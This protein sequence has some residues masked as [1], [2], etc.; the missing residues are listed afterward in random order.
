MTIYDVPVD[1]TVFF[2]VSGDMMRRMKFEEEQRTKNDL[3]SPAKNSPEAADP[4]HIHEEQTVKNDTPIM[5]ED[6]DV[7]RHPLWC[8]E[9]KCLPPNRNGDA[10]LH[11]QNIGSVSFKYAYDAIV[12]MIQAD[13]AAPRAFV[14]TSGEMDL[15]LPEL[16]R[17]IL[18]LMQARRAL[19]QTGEA[20]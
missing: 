16:E 15:S 10:T 20:W 18:V 8:D 6:A 9:T 1:D 13:A 14:T 11:T 17:F 19:A 12:D 3:G 5:S 7:T 4:N 2:P